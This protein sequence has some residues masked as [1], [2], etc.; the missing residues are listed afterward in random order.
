MK[1]HRTFGIRLKLD[2]DDICLLEATRDE[3][4]DV[5]DIYSESA[6][7]LKSTNKST[8]HKHA[9]EETRSEHPLLPSAL[10]QCA[11]DVALEAVKSFNSNNPDKKWKKTPE[12]AFCSKDE[13]DALQRAL[14]VPQRESSH[15]FHCR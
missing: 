8:I 2:E 3:Y 11:R 5:H 6:V 14:Y 13:N 1:I 7:E 10:N 15:A 12:D 9:Y 4:K